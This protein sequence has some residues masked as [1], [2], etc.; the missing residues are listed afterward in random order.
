MNTLL[1]PLHRARHGCWQ[2]GRRGA[3]QTGARAR[4]EAVKEPP[5]LP[6]DTQNSGGR[7]LF[8]TYFGH[9]LFPYAYFFVKL[10]LK[11]VPNPKMVPWAL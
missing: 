3:V 7:P 6:I 10:M 9:D 4:K 11:R 5:D 2:R 1:E 8:W